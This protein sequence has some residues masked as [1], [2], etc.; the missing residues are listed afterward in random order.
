MEDDRKVAAWKGHDT[1]ASTPNDL[2]LSERAPGALYSINATPAAGTLTK[3]AFSDNGAVDNSPFLLAKF[4]TPTIYGGRIYLA[5]F[6]NEIRSYGHDG[7]GDGVPDRFDN[8][9]TV[10]NGD[11]G[12]ANEDAER[13]LGHITL[14]ID[15]LGDA[16]DPNATTAYAPGYSV[17]DG[18]STTCLQISGPPWGSISSSSCPRYLNT[19]LDLY[20][21]IGNSSGV[22][23]PATGTSQPSTT[24]SGFVTRA[25]DAREAIVSSTFASRV[26]SVVASGRN[27]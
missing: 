15:M 20:A 16:C 9:P 11:Q 18:V 3:L 21:S 26:D 1:N 4:T 22:A 24:V 13:A 5:T 27:P 10:G 17:T 2:S 19:G 23:L 25:V 6:S 8:C 7:D 12:N 14:G